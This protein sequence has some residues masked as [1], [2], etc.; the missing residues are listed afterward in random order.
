MNISRVS[1]ENRNTP[2]FVTGFHIHPMHSIDYLHMHV[3][4][5]NQ[6]MIS[7]KRKDGKNVFE[8]NTSSSKFIKTKDMLHVLGQKYEN[9]KTMNI[10][11]SKN[12]T[13]FGTVFNNIFRN[14]QNQNA[15][16]NISNT[17][18]NN[19]SSN[20]INKVIRNDSNILHMDDRCVVFSNNDVVTKKKSRNGDIIDGLSCSKIHLLVIPWM[21][22]Y[23]CVQFTSEHVDLIKHMN[24]VGVMC[25]KTI[26]L[27]YKN[28]GA[29]IPVSSPNY[30]FE[31]SRA[32]WVEGQRLYKAV[33]SNRATRIRKLSTMNENRNMNKN[34]FH[35]F[36]K[37][38]KNGGR[39]NK[40]KDWKQKQPKER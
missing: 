26:A 40:M 36:T 13:Y 17:V 38:S 25:G 35:F 11:S 21:P 16:V 27:K 37:F 3:I 8:Y 12:G 24:K 28:I 1:L 22:I 30:T 2:S 9:M 14:I 6:N 7:K 4:S 19:L 33:L 29:P 32:K 39:F 10:H 5:N 18:Y 31:K 23:N 34:N 20:H 15:S